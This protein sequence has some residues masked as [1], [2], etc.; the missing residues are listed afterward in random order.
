MIYCIRYNY[1]FWL[2]TMAIFRLYMKYLVRS[3]MRLIWVVN[4][5]EVGGEVGTRSRMC[6]RSWEV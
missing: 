4:S 6:H 2:L 1:M 5:G 3:Y